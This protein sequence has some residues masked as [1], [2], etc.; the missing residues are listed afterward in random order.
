MRMD[1][2]SAKNV[3][4]ARSIDLPSRM[5]PG[6]WQEYL[7]ST[8]DILKRS[9]I[10]VENGKAMNYIQFWI[11]EA[12]AEY[13]HGD[14]L[15]FRFADL[16]VFRVKQAVIK[17]FTVPQAML[18]PVTILPWTMELLGSPEKGAFCE[19]VLA[20]AKG[21]VISRQKFAAAAEAAE[22]LTFPEL[23]PG[24]YTV[25]LSLCDAKGKK[26]QSLSAASEVIAP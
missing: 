4:G 7:Y 23:A 9:D 21:K 25:T 15:D 22:A 26:Y 14:K 13:E 1:W 2:R 8:A 6:V 18:A 11:R 16:S 10:P 17:N 5:E 24:K 20:D 12:A 19:I 3:A